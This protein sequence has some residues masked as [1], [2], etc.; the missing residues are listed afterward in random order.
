MAVYRGILATCTSVVWFWWCH[1]FCFT[2]CASDNAKCNRLRHGRAEGLST[3]PY[4][5]MAICPI[6]Y[7][8]FLRYSL[9]EVYL[10]KLILSV[11]CVLSA[12]SLTHL[13]LHSR[14]VVSTQ[15]SP[16]H[17]VVA[18]SDS[19]PADSHVASHDLAPNVIAHYHGGVGSLDLGG[20]AEG[21][22]AKVQAYLDQHQSEA[23]PDGSGGDDV[24][25]DNADTMNQIFVA[26]PTPPSGVYKLFATFNNGDMGGGSVICHVTQVE[27]YHYPM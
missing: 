3:A 12:K 15:G 24:T 20:D 14:Y 4:D 18:A 8:I 23:T 7:F 6:L 10:V 11:L 9:Y 21:E 16:M 1:S 25:D 26:F 27:L 2:W 22:C 19:L 17:L 13:V 5:V